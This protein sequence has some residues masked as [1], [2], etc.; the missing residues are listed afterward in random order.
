MLL[1]I[2]INFV[3]KSLWNV[4]LSPSTLTIIVHL[5]SDH[6]IRY[7]LNNKGLGVHMMLVYNYYRELS[8]DGNCLSSAL[9]ISD[10][11]QCKR[12]IELLRPCCVIF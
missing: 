9:P 7:T 10:I 2:S 8:L 6:N 3:L 5:L 1:L 11:L 4:G 12:Y